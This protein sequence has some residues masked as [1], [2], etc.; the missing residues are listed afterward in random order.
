[1]KFTLVFLVLTMN[2]LMGCKTDCAG[3]W[4]YD[5]RFLGSEEIE[6]LELAA[7][8]WS[9]IAGYDVVRFEPAN[10]KAEMQC[11]VAFYPAD[12]VEDLDGSRVGVN[13][14]MSNNIFIEVHDLTTMRNTL[15]H[16]IGHGFGMDHNEDNPLS[17]MAPYML[18]NP[19]WDEA[20][21]KQCLDLGLC[22]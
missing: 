8:D 11:H 12:D 2:F 7:A 22:R 21:Q 4:T 18:D 16:E 19:I 3:V 10:Q 20:D 1:M 9:R 15:F 17:I 13:K 5:P 6:A 14:Q